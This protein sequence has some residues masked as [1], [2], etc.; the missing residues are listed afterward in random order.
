[1][2]ER[3]LSPIMMGG[4]E[5]RNRIARTAH[6]TM[7]S[8]GGRITEE[9][10]AY[11]AARARGG[12]GLSIL[13]AAGVHRSSLLS[14]ANLDNSIIDGYRALTAAIAPTGMRLFQQLWHGGHIYP[15]PDGGP[16]LAPSD[17]PSHI[18]GI[19]PRPLIR[20]QIDEIIAGYAAAARRCEQGGLDGVEIHAGHGYLIAQFLSPV[21]NRREDEYGGDL[22]G[23][24]LFLRRV[25]GA[26]R[27]AVSP[28]F[29]VG[30]RLSDSADPRILAMSDVAIV[31][32]QV[33]REGLID[34]VNMSYGD[35]YALHR[36]VGGMDAPTGFQIPFTA[37]PVADSRLPRLLNGRFRTLEEVE[38]VLRAG[39]ADLISMVRA[40]IAD[41]DIVAK[42]M[43]GH[44]ERARPCIA[45]NQGC[46]GRVATFGRLG[47][48]VNTAAGDETTLAEQLIA[49]VARPQRVL[50]VG[51]GPAGMEAARIAATAGHHVILAEAMPGLGG[52]TNV[53]RHAPRMGTIGDI[54][55]W[56][57]QEVYR[58][59]VE[60]RL[61]NWLDADDII[62]EGADTVILA[63]GA[64]L[65]P[66]LRQ[67][68][69]PADE[70]VVA[71]GARIISS[72][73]L[74]SERG[75]DRGRSAVVVDE[76]GHYEA[77]ASAEYLLEQGAAVTFVTRHKM[78]AP[79]IDITLRTQSALER[80]HAKGDFTM[81]VGTQ[82]VAAH[83]GSVEIRPQFGGRVE[84][85][86]ADTVVWVP[87]RPGQSALAAQL[88][89][90]GVTPLC[91]GDMLAGR[92]LQTAIRE[93]HLAARGL[94]SRAIVRAPEPVDA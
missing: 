68:Q 84:T 17:V 89:E 21:L 37:P 86:P 18:A 83:P 33:E 58:L 30:V 94:G 90:R 71:P 44:P 14:L 9:L 67:V 87:I 50:I 55:G 61:S 62:A 74:F 56:L 32:A 85:L 1:M 10:I 38:Q 28:G 63:I 81:R 92:N 3:A 73:D 12:V 27:D 66:V 93:G 88:E 25:L 2:Y 39:E 16:P 13:E 72:I 48:V 31:A 77:I 34:Y 41:P 60:V 80:L 82:L 43:A 78:F 79:G 19:A 47:C 91:I 5:V 69:F 7:M 49:P 26:V 65:D 15:A 4:V 57:E 20:G 45:C 76:L 8:R 23:R 75:V 70:V 24:M 6:A 40:H 52:L 64:D 11:H 29:A 36:Q 59:G 42:S 35:Y 54:A 51:G 46:I 22:D 53:Y